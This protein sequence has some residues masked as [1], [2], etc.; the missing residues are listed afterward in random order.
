M[1][2][3]LFL[4][5][6]VR[7]KKLQIIEPD[8]DIANAYLSR[9]LESLSSSKAL[10]NVGNLKDSV[11]LS[12]YAMYHS[13]LALLFRIGVK[14]ENHTAAIILLKELFQ[15]DNSQISH[16]KKERV[17]KQ[18]YVDFTVTHQEVSQAIKT[19]EDFIA[20]IK[21]AIEKLTNVEIARIRRSAAK[22]LGVRFK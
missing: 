19:A 6:L 14:C 22:L 10:L 12:Y 4:R 15:I 17:D 7:E 20:Q 16:A 8:V 21:R 9:A 1:K 2:N 3:Q 5:R 18:Y 13:V 11:A